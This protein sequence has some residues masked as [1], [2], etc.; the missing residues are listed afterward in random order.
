MPHESGWWSMIES[1][2]DIRQKILEA[3]YKKSPANL[4]QPAFQGGRAI[5]ANYVWSSDLL[6]CGLFLL[7]LSKLGILTIACT[8]FW[9][10]LN[11]GKKTFAL[12]L[13][14]K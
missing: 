1:V 5:N 14:V 4:R 3:G 8:F 2:D 7:W 9:I 11:F 13:K 12:K 10:I 6:W